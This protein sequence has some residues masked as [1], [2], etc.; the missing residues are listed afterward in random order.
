MKDKIQKKNIIN[1][2]LAVFIAV[3]LILGIVTA[4]F[5]ELQN[6]VLGI[7]TSIVFGVLVIAFFVLFYQKQNLKRNCVFVIIFILFFAIGLSSFCVR[8]SNYKEANLNGHYFAVQGKVTEV[9]STDSGSMAILSDVSVNGVV[10]GELEYKIS[11]YVHGEKSLDVGDYVKFS[12]NLKDKDLIYENVFTPYDITNK[13]KYFANVN[14]SDI[15]VVGKRLTIFEKC[16]LFIRD[17]LKS[18]LDYD[19]FTVAYGMLAGQTELMDYNV[20]SAYR[21]LGVAHIFAV[22]GLHIGFIAVALNFLLNKLK[23]PR[24]IKAIIITTILFFYSGICGFTASSVRATIM[25]AV[26]L[27]L[28]A[29]GERYDG[30]SALAIAGIIILLFSPLQLFC[31]GF[32]L[33]FVVVLG[34][35]LLAKPIEKLL[36]KLIKFIP[37]KVSSSIGVALSAQLASIVIS[38]AHFGYFSLIS[39]LTNVIL[40]PIMGIIFYLLF[41]LTILGG[42]LTI[43][44]IALF[45]PNYILKFA[46]IILTSIDSEKLLI[47]GVVIG[48]FSSFYYVAMIIPSGLINLKSITKIVATSIALSIFLTGTIVLNVAKKEYVNVYV[49][50]SN[51]ASVTVITTERE[52]VLI[53]SDVQKIFS[54]GNLRRLSSRNG[55]FDIDAVIIGG[56]FEYDMQTFV[57]RA[58]QVFNL[59]NIYYF[60]DT[61]TELE[62]LMKK[63][64]ASLMLTS[65][66]AHEKF[67][68]EAIC[69]QFSE[70]G[71]AVDLTIKDRRI[72]V[73]SNSEIITDYSQ[74]GEGMSVLIAGRNLEQLEYKLKPNKLISYR[75][76]NGFE[77]GESEGNFL[78][79]FK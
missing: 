62:T 20:I 33:S 21:Y 34:V 65:F 47:S 41:T 5:F 25:S 63:S 50:G 58:R 66:N 54:V 55:V 40:I 42:I 2:R 44:H 46:N 77:N 28:S 27:F 16:N 75:K 79:S 59:E 38:L 18:G 49:C 26:M 57:S 74:L 19:E 43:P 8:V 68:L 7:T 60:G 10:D 39:V 69:G 35:L 37:K 70:N 78:Y 9:Q 4:Y 72:V 53:V 12:A 23:T 13:I 31:V 6:T 73:L 1:L 67:P 24:L 64:F 15:E 30:L 3:S 76:A 36:T 17:T 56:G 51:T 45:L 11:L 61:N 14:A 22:S 29:K 48:G 71:L 52:N 32:Q